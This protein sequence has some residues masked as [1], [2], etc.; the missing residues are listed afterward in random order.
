[1][2]AELWKAMDT[3]ID[4]HELSDY[5]VLAALARSR[6]SAHRL[7]GR[8]CKHIY[9]SD[10]PSIDWQTVSQKEKSFMRAL[11]VEVITVIDQTREELE[12]DLEAIDNCRS[13]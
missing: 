13:S 10:L 1:M 6:T 11:G 2:R 9:E 12:A 8:A 7:D 3:L 4:L 5:P